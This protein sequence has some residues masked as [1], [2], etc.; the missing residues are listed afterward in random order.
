MQRPFLMRCPTC[1]RPVRFYNEVLFLS[2][3]TMVINGLCKA[4]P[5]CGPITSGPINLLEL[6]PHDQETRED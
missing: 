6:V 1:N 5:A 3:F 2:D 4:T